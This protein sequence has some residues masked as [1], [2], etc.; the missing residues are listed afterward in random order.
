MCV[1][2]RVCFGVRMY[3][4]MYVYLLHFSLPRTYVI[5]TSPAP[6]LIHFYIFGPRTYVI[7]TFPAAR[8]FSSRV[9]TGPG[10]TGGNQSY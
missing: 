2:A 3:V 8:E 6:Y 1:R 9:K 5:F 10:R 7:F 4:F